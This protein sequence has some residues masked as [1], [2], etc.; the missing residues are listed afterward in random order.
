MPL[1]NTLTALNL[2]TYP[3]GENDKLVVVFSRER[4][5]VRLAA[6]GARKTGNKWAGRLEPL[7]RN[8]IQVSRGRGSIEVL[9]SADTRVSGV[10]LMGDLDRVMTGLRLAEVTKALLPEAEPYVEVFDAFETA[11]DLIMER[12]SPAIV[13]LW[14]ELL[15][16]DAAGYRPEFEACVVCDAPVWADPNPPAGSVLTG[17]RGRSDPTSAAAVV[18]YS[19]TAGGVR[20]ERCSVP[21]RPVSALSV[22][23][24]RALQG[25]DPVLLRPVEAPTEITSEAADILTEAISR[26][27]QT[28]LHS[29][30]LMRKLNT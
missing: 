26:H 8:A 12:V 22:R 9:T 11:L 23:L 20:C 13:G 25:A 16:L 2:R 6:R 29:V 27:A 24:L 15:L 10:A 7:A 18:A 17:S 14:F 3:L 21:A 19:V 5:V 28:D 30:D 4:G 1:S